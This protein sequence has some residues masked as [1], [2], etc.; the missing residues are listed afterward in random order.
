MQNCSGNDMPMNKGDKLAKL[1]SP[2]SDFEKQE[3][4]NKP[5]SGVVGSLMYTQVCTRPDI[6]FAVGMLARVEDLELTGYTD[7]DFAGNYPDSN[8]STSW[9]VFVLAGGAIAWKSV[10]QGLIATSTMQAEY[11]AI[12]EGL[13]QGLWLRNFLFET[14]VLDSIVSVARHV[15]SSIQRR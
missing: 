1:D 12:Y 10:K 13:C 4:K 2:I 9:Y 6:A 11:I 15:K 8:K 5:F 14:K 3:M 7:S